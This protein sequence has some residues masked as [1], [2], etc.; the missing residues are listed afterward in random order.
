[1]SDINEVKFSKIDSKKT[2]TDDEIKR[3]LTR[4]DSKLSNFRKHEG[5]HRRFDLRPSAKKHKD[6]DLTTHKPAG[7]ETI[8]QGGGTSA[9]H[10][11]NEMDVR[12]LNNLKSAMRHHWKETGKTKEGSDRSPAAKAKKKETAAKNR[13]S[14]YATRNKGFSRVAGRKDARK[15]T[16]EQFMFD[17]NEVIDYT[18]PPTPDH[19][20]EI[21]N[22]VQK[23]KKCS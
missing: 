20:V 2:A 13:E 14:K 6:K 23:S 9:T 3:A 8:H 11:S 16:F 15:K 22:V 5:S 21:R 7:R 1:M 4:K 10:K 19:G 17:V 12:A 18:P